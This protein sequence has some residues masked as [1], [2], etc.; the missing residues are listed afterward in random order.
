MKNKINNGIC[1]ICG[2]PTIDYTDN[3][4]PDCFKQ[5]GATYIIK[6]FCDENKNKINTKFKIG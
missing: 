2:N 6:E 3:I 5:D 1:I 4:C